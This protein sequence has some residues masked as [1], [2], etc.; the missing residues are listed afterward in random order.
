MQENRTTVT[1]KYNIEELKGRCF[2]VSGVDQLEHTLSRRSG[3]FRVIMHAVHNKL[4]SNSNDS[5]LA[6]GFSGVDSGR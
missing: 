1:L 3:H 5:L 2:L 4:V 6:K